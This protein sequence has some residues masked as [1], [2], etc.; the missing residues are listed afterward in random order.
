MIGGWN[1][2][3]LHETEVFD[4]MNASRTCQPIRECPDTGL[5]RGMELAV[6]QGI[7]KS[8]GAQYGNA[9]YCHDYHPANDTWIRSTDML[10][11]RDYL[12]ASFIGNIWLLSGSH[13]HASSRTK[14]EKWTGNSF[15]EGPIVPR[16][17]DYH[18]QLTINETYV[19]FAD[20][21]GQPNYLLNW[22]D[23]T[24]LELPPM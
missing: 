3:A 10:Y 12:R 5:C 6:V 15:L 21:D 4:L 22:P 2:S 16:G 1:G 13:N 24:W 8:C 9:R 23:Q 14:T 17:M 11:E 19:F 18:C 7:I 20:S